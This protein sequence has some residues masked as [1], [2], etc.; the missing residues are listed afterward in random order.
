MKQRRS[1]L[2]VVVV[3]ALLL[4]PAAG[5]FMPKAPYTAGEPDAYVNHNLAFR[6]ALITLH[7]RLTELAFQQS[8][9]TEVILGKDGWLFF[10]DTLD[11][12]LAR[13][14]MED[15]EITAIADG[16]AAVSAQLKSAGKDGLFL[17][18]T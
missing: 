15:A 8:G 4:L 17:C 12:Y 5:L 9:S 18:A 7:G 6:D 1:L 2:F 14:P 10:A 13:T 16:L 11:G 3:M